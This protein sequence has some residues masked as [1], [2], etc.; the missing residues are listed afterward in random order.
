MPARD[1]LLHDLVGP[2]L[3]AGEDERPRERRVLQK[4]RQQVRLVPRLDEVHRL[5]DQLDRR[6][7][8]APLATYAGS[9]SHSLASLR[10]SGGIVAENISVCRACG[11]AR[12]DPPQRHD[13]AHVEHL[14]GLVENQ[15]LD[16]AQVDVALLH[17]VEQPAGRGDED[18]DAVLQR[19][20]LRPLAD[21]AVDDGVS[22]AG[23][24]AV[25]GEALADLGR[26]LARRREDQRPDRPTIGRGECIAT[27]AIRLPLR[28]C[29]RRRRPGCTLVLNRCNVGSANAAV[30]PVPVWAQPIRSRPASTAEWL[31]VGSAWPCGSPRRARRGGANRPGQVVKTYSMKSL[32]QECE[33]LRCAN[34]RAETV[35]SQARQLRE[36]A[37]PLKR[38]A[39]TKR[40]KKISRGRE[41]DTGATCK[42]APMAAAIEFE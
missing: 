12:H 9:R 13:E 17:Q 27:L 39:G 5:L 19:P 42:I 14:V 30:L 33:L 16:V 4:V 37:Q 25:G 35:S 31:G 21:A 23:E 38:S 32:F 3:G 36:L 28:R 6:G 2:V 7:D 26:Q 1:Q 24:P 11:T 20:H 10:I 40:S 41:Q 22:Q 34:V 8:R 29:V 18:V 15:D